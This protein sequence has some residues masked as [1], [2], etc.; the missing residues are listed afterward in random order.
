[1]REAVRRTLPFSLWL[2]GISLAYAGQYAL[3][4]LGRVAWGWWLLGVGAAAV[5]GASLLLGGIQTGS[6]AVIEERRGGSVRF[7]VS[8]ALLAIGLDGAAVALVAAQHGYRLASGL[9]LA[10]LAVAVLA[11][12]AKDRSIGGALDARQVPAG[13]RSPRSRFFGEAAMVMGLA[14]LAVALRL[15]HL[16]TI[17][18][19]VHGD[20]AACGIAARLLLHGDELNLFGIGWAT[21]PNVGYALS[22]ASMAVFGDDLF[23]FRMGSVILGT[24]SVLLAYGLARSVFS[25]PVAAV[26]AFL[27]AVGHWSIHFGRSGIHYIHATFATL[28]LFFFFHR[29]MAD[30]RLRDYVLAGFAVG[31]CFSVYFGARIAPP[32]VPLFCLH[33]TVFERGF[34]RRHAGGL[35][36]ISIAAA[37]FF[38]PQVPIYAR[39]PLTFLERASSVWVFA[40]DN[41]RHELGAY[42]VPELRDVILRQ[43]QK[44]VEAFNRVGE[45]S[46]QYGHLSPLLDFWTGPLFVVGMAAATL[47]PLSSSAFF[48]ATWFWATLVMGAILTV[49][50]LFSPRVVALM[51][52]LYLAAAV[53]LDVGWRAAGRAFGAGGKRIVLGLAVLVCALAL[54]A[55]V[56]DYFVV[57]VNQAQPAGFHTVLSEYV[58]RLNDRYKIYY[59]ARRDMS[60]HYDTE[61]FLIPGVDGYEMRAGALAL[62]LRSP[63][64]DKGALFI[65]E[66]EAPHLDEWLASIHQAY[67]SAR[68]RMVRSDRGYPFFYAVLVERADLVAALGSA[69]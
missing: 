48:L 25:M 11:A 32:L 23:G 58:R 60:L 55:N 4:P 29:A 5:A 65:L 63:P 49:D 15:P 30:R 46:L 59:I 41:V 69:R 40:P 1:M 38:A 68:Q 13:D 18:P 17:P 61:A 10:A 52:A 42:H 50:A 45:T 64:A 21:L 34:L 57:H 19:E 28:L 33:R 37:L 31:L 44:S 8:L 12:M 14:A 27:F 3:T 7:A 39:N 47:Q 26:G 20:E 24:A 54:R 36:L 56:Y 66:T 62:P 22:A 67:P 6:E 43:A 51:P 16:A 53:G 2:I 35:L 9:W